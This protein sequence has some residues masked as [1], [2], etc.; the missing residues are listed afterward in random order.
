M[1]VAAVKI[2]PEIELEQKVMKV[3]FFH[4]GMLCNIFYAL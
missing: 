2:E 3:I 4:R 1:S